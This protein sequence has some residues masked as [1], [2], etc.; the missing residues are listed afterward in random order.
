[1]TRPDQSPSLVEQPPSALPILY[2]DD[3][4]VAVNKPA[5]L[6]VHRSEID[7]HETQFALQ[8][9]RDQIG[10]RV[11]P[12]HRLDKPTAGVLV[13]ALQP[14]FA[15]KMMTLFGQGGVEKT[16]LAV[17]RGWT[18][19]VLTIDHPLVEEDKVRSPAPSLPEPPAQPAITDLRRLAVVELPFPVG[20]HPTCRYSLVR[21]NPKTGRRHQLRRHLKHIFHP[22]LGDTTHGDGRQNALFRKEFDC[23]RLLLAAVGMSFVHPVT[24]IQVELRAPLDEGFSGLVARFGWEAACVS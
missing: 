14:D 21:L 17:V 4:L 19:E 18:P 5:G 16:Y 11:F 7:R 20:P 6:L 23:A 13:F 8:M 12:V 3:F 24:G 9:V 22:I 15:A 10:Q 2:R 1:M